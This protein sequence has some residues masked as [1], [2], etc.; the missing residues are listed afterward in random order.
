MPKQV[1]LKTFRSETSVVSQD[2]ESFGLSKDI[3]DD[4]ALRKV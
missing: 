2:H 1:N 4:E 3:K